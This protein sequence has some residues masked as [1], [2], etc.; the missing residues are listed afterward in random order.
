MTDGEPRLL[1][2]HFWANDDMTRLARVL[3]ETLDTTKMATK[4][5]AAN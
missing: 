3:R 4:P 5:A 1:F 2:V